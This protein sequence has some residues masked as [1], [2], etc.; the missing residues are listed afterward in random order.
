MDLINQYTSFEDYG[1]TWEALGAYFSQPEQFSAVTNLVSDYGFSSKDIT[2]D[3]VL[4]AQSTMNQM[5]KTMGEVD[6]KAAAYTSALE[7][8]AVM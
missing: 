5:D 3:F 2:M 7:N 1:R 4:A 6:D 8:S